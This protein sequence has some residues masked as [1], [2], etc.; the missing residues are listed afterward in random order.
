[1]DRGYKRQMRLL[2]DAAKPYA[3]T[4]QEKVSPE[5]WETIIRF[6]P[7]CELF[8]EQ[9]AMAKRAKDIVLFQGYDDDEE[10]RGRNGKRRDAEL[11]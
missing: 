11:N 3:D 8:G 10:K 5:L 2:R 4:I 6:G 9:K 7:L 1:M